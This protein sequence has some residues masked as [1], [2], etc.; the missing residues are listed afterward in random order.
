MA[1]NSEETWRLKLQYE[2][3]IDNLV[4]ISDKL[5]GIYNYLKKAENNF[6]SGGYMSDGETLDQGELKKCC[7]L[8]ENDM[9]IL[10]NVITKTRYILED[11]E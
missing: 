11:L 3:Y 4:Y 2:S 5:P 8:I 9:D 7:D 1:V 10:H 6:L